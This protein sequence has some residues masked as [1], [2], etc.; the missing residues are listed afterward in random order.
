MTIHLVDELTVA[1]G[2]RAELLAR[3]TS[4]YLPLVAQSGVQCSRA[5]CHPPEDVPGE[6]TDLVLWWDLDDVAAVWKRRTQALDGLEAQFW[7]DVAPLLL[8]RR[9]RYY[10]D[11]DLG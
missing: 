5:V 1:P 4:D 7:A 2:R 6:P 3:L 10:D 9:R 11:V 8:D